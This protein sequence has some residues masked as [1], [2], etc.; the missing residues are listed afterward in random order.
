M[1]SPEP[2]EDRPVT[3]LISELAAI[4]PPFSSLG[5]PFLA[6]TEVT[7]ELVSRGADAVPALTAALASPEPRI[8]LYAAYC[9]GLIGDRSVLP[10]LRRIRE[11]HEQRRP[12]LDTDFSIVGAIIQAEERLAGS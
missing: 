7:R 4:E 6:D 10:I 3:E 11:R 2:V 5:M 9:L 12:K 1:E 8:V